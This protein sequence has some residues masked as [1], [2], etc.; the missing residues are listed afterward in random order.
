VTP[1]IAGMES[2]AKIRSVEKEKSEFHSAAFPN[3]KTAVGIT[4]THWQV[5]ARQLHHTHFFDVHVGL[6]K[7]HVHA[8]IKY[9]GAEQIDDPRE[10]FQQCDAG[11]NHH[12]AHD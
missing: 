11:A 5:A 6:V 1:K 8:R 9:V 4:R 7:K 2:R 12:A 10:F 3:N